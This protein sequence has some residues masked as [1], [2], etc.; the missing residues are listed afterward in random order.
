MRKDLRVVVVG[1]GHV[2]Y[3]TAEALHNR[4]HDVVVVE[5]DA[6]RV[7]FL[8]D[9]YV[10]TVIHGDG[11]RPDVLRQADLDRSDVVAALTDRG[12][13]TN[14]GICATAERIAPEIHTVARTDQPE[15]PEFHEMVDAAVYPGKLAANAAANQVIQ[16]SGG[17]VRTIEQVTADLE[18]V[19]IEIDP[20]APAAGKRLE[21]VAFPRGAVVV[22][23]EHR[24]QFPGPDTVLEPGWPYVLAVPTSV[25]DEVVRL[26]RG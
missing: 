7:E 1:G 4:G 11:G 18:L 24:G 23:D 2:G 21:E 19:E 3:N 15:E 10:A 17:G 22:A 9:S 8:N 16:V 14:L 20:G 5:Q 6:E 26:L 25:T 12:T 13:M